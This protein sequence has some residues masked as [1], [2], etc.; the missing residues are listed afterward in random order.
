M[1]TQII[2][3]FIGFI[4]LISSTYFFIESITSIAK[5]IHFPKE[6]INLI[7]TLFLPLVPSFALL[8]KASTYNLS[9]LILGSIIGSSIINISIILIINIFKPIKL[10]ETTIN[11]DIPL[12]IL[13]TSINIIL[14]KDNLF[15]NNYTNIITKTDGLILILLFTIFISN[16][17]KRFNVNKQTYK[18]NNQTNFGLALSII[19]LVISIFGLNVGSS[20]II[21][22]IS[23]IS[24]L[25][26][27]TVK[28]LS[29]T[30]ISLI[31]CM[32]N[33]INIIISY[34]Q[35]KTPIYD[36][37]IQHSIINT[38]LILGSTALLF[39][40]IE[41]KNYNY[42]DIIIYILPITTI[43][44]LLK[45][46]NNITKKESILILT[47]TLLYYLYIHTK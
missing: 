40:E 30:L 42:I 31:I 2:L 22:A 5:N 15:N 18:E 47:L 8:W 7:H 44:F 13:I 21:E 11:Q 28:M 9:D 37:I 43:Y 19:Y 25:T 45:K 3:I 39:N 14:F 10:K 32:P 1:Y 4:I 38:S 12:L 36:G 24:I 23:K 6:I 26:T 16:T 29:L 41:T 17:I 35:N 33:I 34:K 46:K 27:I 20:F